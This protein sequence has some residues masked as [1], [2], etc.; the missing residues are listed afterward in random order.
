MSEKKLALDEKELELIRKAGTKVHY[1]KN[2]IIFAAGDFANRVYLIEE[3]WVKNYRLDTEGRKV[4]AGN[5]RNPGELVGLAEAL[6][7]GERMCFASSLTE[8]SLV[9]LTNKQFIDILHEHNSLTLKVAIIMAAR[10]RK[11]EEMSH[12]LVC[13]QVPGRLASVLLRLANSCGMETD[14][15][16]KLGLRLTHEEIASMIGTSRQTVTSIL[17]MFK[18]ENSVSI[19]NREIKILDVKKLSSWLV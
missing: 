16:I 6:Y 3:G 18:Q 12:E 13:L 1:P 10:F 2:H 9:H 14:G 11:S 15:G 4:T 19:E 8:V 17:S 5:I 7:Q